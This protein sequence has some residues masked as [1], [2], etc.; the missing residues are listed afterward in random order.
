[1]SCWHHGL[2][3]VGQRPSIQRAHQL[4]LRDPNRVHINAR[5]PRTA[6]SGMFTE[7]SDRQQL[8]D[9]ANWQSNF[10]EAS[11]SGKSRPV[12]DVRD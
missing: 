3:L 10:Q 9:S 8:A 12:F 1:M 11:A 4:S 2:D 6:A 5:N 7:G